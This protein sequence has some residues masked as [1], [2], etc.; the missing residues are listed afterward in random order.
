MLFLAKL[1]L[2]ILIFLIGSS[3]HLL[4]SD[5]CLKS[6]VSTL[7]SEIYD[8]PPIT[9][10]SMAEMNLNLKPEQ[11]LPESYLKQLKKASHEVTLRMKS[12]KQGVDI[13]LSVDKM[14][15]RKKDILELSLLGGIDDPK[16]LTIDNLSIKDPLNVGVAKLSASQAEKGLPI[17]VVNHIKKQFFQIAKA[18]GYEKIG[19]AG[20]QNFLVTLFYLR[21][22]GMKPA[23]KKSYQ[24][25]YILINK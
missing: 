9:P 23:D 17:A 13:K 8:S 6:V 24:F 7:N 4:S 19:A 14:P 3:S 1:K 12:S 21:S 16:T 2:F 25:I 20:T 18:G 10:W 5:N 15:P 11:I 22:I